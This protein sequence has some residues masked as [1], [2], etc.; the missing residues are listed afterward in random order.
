MANINEKLAKG[1]IHGRFII[2]LVGKPKEHIEKAMLMIINKIKE[3]Q[4]IEIVRQESAEAKELEKQKGFFSIFTEIE[5]LLENLPVLMGFCYDFMPSSVEI[6]APEELKTNP[7]EINSILN[8]LQAKLHSLDSVSKQL[9]MENQFLKNNTKRLLT[10]SISILLLRDGKKYES[11]A[12]ILGF[13]PKDLKP[14]L[15]KM[16]EEG[17]LKKQEDKYFLMKK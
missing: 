7:N 2:E 11:I 5:L 14:F 15:D 8:D 13:E 4:D 10:N 6:L 17:K 3:S 9:N 12:K 1:C 16:V